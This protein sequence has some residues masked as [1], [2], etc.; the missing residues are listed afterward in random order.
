MIERI[1]DFA[2]RR[3]RRRND[4]RKLRP[5]RFVGGGVPGVAVAR[6]SL[7]RGDGRRGAGVGGSAVERSILVNPKADFEPYGIRRIRPN[8]PVQNVG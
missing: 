6:S 3:R 1:N 4:R 2:A 7:A 8:D 5:N